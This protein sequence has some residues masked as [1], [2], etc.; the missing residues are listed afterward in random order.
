ESLAKL[1]A[2]ARAETDKAA[3]LELELAAVTA[4]LAASALR[5]D[6]TSSEVSVQRERAD[7][8]VADA[9]KLEH[10]VTERRS[11]QAQL[12]EAARRAGAAAEERS[13]PGG[14]QTQRLDDAGA[15]LLVSDETIERV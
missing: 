9:A 11:L 12:R 15:A 3:A 14:G 6:L 10:K 5:S 4:A 7:E 2:A 8:L 13:V 1:T